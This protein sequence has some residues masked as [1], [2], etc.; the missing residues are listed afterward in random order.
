IDRLI[1]VIKLV[2]D[3]RVIIAGN[4]EE[5]L[6]PKLRV[7]AEQNGV[8]D[9]VGF[10]GPVSGAAK[11]ELLQTSTALV[12]PSLSENFG[13]V[14]LEAMAAE[15][16]VIVTPEVGLAAEVAQSGAGIV[17]SGL[18]EPLSQAIRG[19]LDD[20]EL[21]AAMGKRGR[22]LVNARFTWDYV[23]AQMEEQYRRI[24]KR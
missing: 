16:P 22:E 18:P 4:D 12:L 2:P 23:A 6:T 9:R 24:T 19:L 13:N 3:V 10:R 11:E 17:T 1:D 15:M 21:R 20:S 7:Q 5:D 8:A 14:I